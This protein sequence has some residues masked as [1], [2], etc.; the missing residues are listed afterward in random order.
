MSANKNVSAVWTVELRCDCPKCGQWVDLLDFTDFW[1]G[2]KLE[3][4]EN[5][6]D[7]SQDVEV[8]CPECGHEFKVDCEY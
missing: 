3:I 2:R 1:E 6:T 7:N 8:D 5:G 4:A